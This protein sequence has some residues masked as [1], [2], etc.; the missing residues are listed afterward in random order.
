V[1]RQYTLHRPVRPTSVHINY[2]AELNEQQLATVTAAR[3]RLVGGDDYFR[4]VAKTPKKLFAVLPAQSKLGDISEAEPADD[5][6]EKID[7]GMIEVAVHHRALGPIDQPRLI[8]FA[9]E[10]FGDSI[11]YDLAGDL[12]WV[13]AT[14]HIFVARID[15]EFLVHGHK[16]AGDVVYL[17]RE[18]G[19]ILARID[20]FDVASA[21][22][23]AADVFANVSSSTVRQF[24]PSF[25]F[26]FVLRTRR[27]RR[28][29]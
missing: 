8:E 23:G 14:L 24:F 16:F 10:V 17:L 19:R 1:S 26:P 29:S 4:G 18:S 11:G 3:G 2:E 28:A 7:V 12:H 21:P 27:H 25:E 15:G 22:A 20:F 13:A 6:G 9:V 5:F